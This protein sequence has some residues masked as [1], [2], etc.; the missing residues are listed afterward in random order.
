M[1]VAPASALPSVASTIKLAV[2]VPFA[3]EGIGG[4]SAVWLPA[5]VVSAAS[6]IASLICADS[7]LFTARGGASSARS[8]T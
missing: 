7:S 2:T 5:T 1:T 3:S 6:G 4:T 8:R